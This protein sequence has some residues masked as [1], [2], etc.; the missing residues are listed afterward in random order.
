MNISSLYKN[1]SLIVLSIS[2]IIFFFFYMSRLGPEV[3]FMDSLSFLK[4]YDLIEQGQLSIWDVW[5]NIKGPHKGFFS[6]IFEY[7]NAKYFS[8][9]TNLATKLIML[10]IFFSALMIELEKN[11]TFSKGNSIDPPLFFYFFSL[12]IFM[13]AFSLSSWELY[14]L[15]IGFCL[16]FKTFIFLLF[17][18]ILSSCIKN[19]YTVNSK[20]YYFIKVF[21]IFF[22]PAIVFIFAEGWSY[23]FIISTILALFLSDSDSKFLN[24]KFFIILSLLLSL[25]VYSYLTYDYSL[26][27]PFSDEIK[28]SFSNAFYGLFYGVASIFIGIESLNAMQI[29]LIFILFF[30][31]FFIAICL[32]LLFLDLKRDLDLTF[33][34]RVL[35][36]YGLL[37][38]ISIA[39]SRGRYGPAYTGASRYF[40]DFSLVFIG[41]YWALLVSISSKARLC[42][43]IKFFLKS[44]TLFFSLSFFMGWSI[45]TYHEWNKAPYRHVVFLEMRKITLQNSPITIEQAALLQR[46]IEDAQKGVL[47]QRKYKLGPYSNPILFK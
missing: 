5:S 43:R 37:D 9:N 29:P 47:I 36:L 26:K 24:F 7:S 38:L 32:F 31:L 17:W 39:Y 16:F 18:K 46:S 28:P 42:Y 22:A 30:G 8:L 14:S 44:T 11:S 33:F 20:P 6:L 34:I 25:F 45:T 10:P 2:S 41:M 23:A 27:N 19:S 12:I 3:I 15:D 40:L 35:L 4:S 13:C 1:T 21:I